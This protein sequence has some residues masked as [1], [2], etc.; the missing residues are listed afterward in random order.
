MSRYGWQTTC[1]LPSFVWPKQPELKGSYRECRGSDKQHL[2][3]LRRKE[4]RRG[5][6]TPGG[7]VHLGNDSASHFEG[8]A[9][10]IRV[11]LID[12]YGLIVED[13]TYLS[14]KHRRYIITAQ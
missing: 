3:T 8:S 14:G 12:S 9:D 10:S 13:R 1:R 6:E 2:D 4:A 7:S 11:R 5:A